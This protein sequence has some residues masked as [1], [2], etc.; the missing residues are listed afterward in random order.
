MRQWI[1]INLILHPKKDTRCGV[2]FYARM[3]RQHQ[4]FVHQ[5]RLRLH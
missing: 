4:A 5:E 2:F 3:S 1:E